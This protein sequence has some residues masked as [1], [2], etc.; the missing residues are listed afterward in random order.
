[1]SAKNGNKHQPHIFNDKW[2]SVTKAN[3]VFLFV[4]CSNCYLLRLISYSALCF[5]FAYVT[6]NSFSLFIPF[7]VLLVSFF[8]LFWPYNFINR[9]QFRLQFR[10]KDSIEHKHIQRMS[11]WWQCISSTTFSCQFLC[12]RMSSTAHGTGGSFRLSIN[13]YTRWKQCFWRCDGISH[14]NDNRTERNITKK[15]S[16]KLKKITSKMINSIN[17]LFLD[18]CVSPIVIYLHVSHFFFLPQF[19]Q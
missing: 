9:L 17:L 14:I 12:E 15:K 5:L 1:M 8:H 7:N 3:A 18:G 6:C 2:S 10:N 16:R 13:H 19:A 11:F 4:L